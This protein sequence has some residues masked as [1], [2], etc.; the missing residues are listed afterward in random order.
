[1]AFTINPPN[2][3]LVDERGMVSP[4]WYRFFANIQRIIGDDAIKQFAEAP[5]LTFAASPVFSNER[6][7]AGSAAIRLAPAAPLM[8][9]E[10]RDT[11]VVPRA[12]GGASKA[13][14]ITVDQ[15]GR[16]TSA[17]EFDL[18][19]GNIAEGANLYYTQARARAAISG[20]GGV[21][22]DTGTGEASLDTASGRNVDHST[23]HVAAGVGLTGGGAINADRTLALAPSGVTAGVYASPTSIT[24]D[25]YGRITAIS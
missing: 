22:Y 6:I 23:V 12:Y 4:V 14:A 3:A 13:A 16:V 25:Q 8:T 18:N 11:A 2:T 21:S 10:L 17:Q 1:M 7:L 9:I 24:V 20:T 5:V 15:Q 19:T